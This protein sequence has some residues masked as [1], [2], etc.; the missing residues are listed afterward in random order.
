MNGTFDLTFKVFNEMAEWFST[1]PTS[2]E[3]RFIERF[4]TECGESGYVY[5][6]QWLDEDRLLGDSFEETWAMH[7]YGK[8]LKVGEYDK[9]KE[10]FQNVW[11]NSIGYRQFLELFDS[12]SY[13]YSNNP[14]KFDENNK[15]KWLEPAVR[16][17]YI[18]RLVEQGWRRAG[19]RKTKKVDFKLPRYWHLKVKEYWFNG[20]GDYMLV[21]NTGWAYY[22]KV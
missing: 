19:K 9:V 18:A 12:F 8:C 3:I 2:A 21:T 10:L 16:E 1:N 22:A 13:E 20:K 5:R 7:L 14:L 4:F 11:M 17:L 6:N 15:A